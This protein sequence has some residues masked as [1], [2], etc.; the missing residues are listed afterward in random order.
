V[1]EH[2]QSRFG[3]ENR[4]ASEHEIEGDHVP[5]RDPQELFEAGHWGG[6][7]TAGTQKKALKG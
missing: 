7:L 3:S 6:T 5:V 4:A 1:A 2:A